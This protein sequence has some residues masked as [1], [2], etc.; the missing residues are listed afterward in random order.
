MHRRQDR[1]SATHVNSPLRSG[2]RHY[3]QNA[4]AAR[5]LRP[6]RTLIA[7]K[8]NEPGGAAACQSASAFVN[9]CGAGW[10]LRTV[11][12]GGTE[13]N[14]SRD[15][16]RMFPIEPYAGQFT[17]RDNCHSSWARH[18]RLITIRR[19]R[20][21]ASESRRNL[22]GFDSDDVA[23]GVDVIAAIV[24]HLVPRLARAGEYWLAE[25]PFP[26]SE[27]KCHTTLK[28]EEPKGEK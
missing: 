8:L 9:F 22:E 20:S 16:W 18:C 23:R 4:S 14:R 7:P 19:A 13:N 11:R 2:L 25:W 24:P 6:G 21:Q 3:L 17:F 26:C 5:E 12:C 27:M 15:R 10:D 1:L 28:P